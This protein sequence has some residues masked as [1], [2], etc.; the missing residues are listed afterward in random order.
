VIAHPNV[1]GPGIGMISVS[2]NGSLALTMSAFLSGISATLA[3]QMYVTSYWTP[4]WKRTGCGVFD[5][6]RMCQLPVPVSEDDHDCKAG[7]PSTEGSQQRII[8]VVTYLKAGHLLEVPYMH[9]CP[10]GFHT[11]IWSNVMF[12]GEPKAH[13]VAQLDLWGRAHE[14]FKCH[15]DKSTC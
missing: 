11:A 10:S 6:N 3:S 1:K 9:F 7:Y 2:H 12:G 15:L 5:F 4:P 8:Q 13:R 14:F